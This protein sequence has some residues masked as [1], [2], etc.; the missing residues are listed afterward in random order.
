M[1]SVAKKQKRVILFFTGFGKFGKVLE[2]PTTHLSRALSK[3][4]EAHPIDGVT[5]YQNYV[6]TVSI[7]HCDEALAEIYGKINALIEQNE[8]EQSEYDNHYVVLHMGVY[9][10]SGQFN[11]EVQGKNIKNFGIPDE[12]GN[13]PRDQCIWEDKE[14]GHFIQTR[15]DIDS[16]VKNLKTK[17][18]KVG[19]SLS[20]GDYICNYTYFCS[21]KHKNHAVKNPEMVD[22]LFCHVPTFE[23]ID[24]ESQQKF[25]MDL[26]Q[27][28][29]DH[30]LS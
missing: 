6:V 15:F 8:K 23:E 9:Q 29:R 10:R 13:Q 24:E 28:I 25:L 3:L 22:S 20:A 18:H 4:L 19:K 2:N 5:L 12:N 17:G 26:I 30:I 7:E 14:K 21:L 1:E 16:F 27:E 11:V